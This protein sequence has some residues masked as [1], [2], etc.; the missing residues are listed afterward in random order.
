[1]KPE[2]AKQWVDAL[3]S[4]K[5]KQAKGYLQTN[6]GYCCLGVLCEIA[7]PEIAR[8]SYDKQTD[9]HKFDGSVGIIPQGVEEW[10]GMQS[11]TGYTGIPTMSVTGVLK[12]LALTDYNDKEDW[13]FNRI[14]DFIEKNAEKL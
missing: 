6:E 7:P 5:Y 12:T 8:S 3:R 11:C 1:M 4:G 9:L 13:D 10:A 14:A 2:I